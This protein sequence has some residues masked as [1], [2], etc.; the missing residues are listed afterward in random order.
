[1]SIYNFTILQEGGKALED[2]EY[3]VSEAAKILNITRQS[4]YNKVN[5]LKDILQ[6]Y[7]VIKNKTKYLTDKAVEIIRNDLNGDIVKEPFYNI[8]KH[9]FTTFTDLTEQYKSQIKDLQ[10]SVELMKSVYESQIEFIKDDYSKQLEYI[11]KE[12]AKK[13]DQLETKDRLLENM[14]VL[15]RDQK[16]LIDSMKKKPWWQFW[17]RES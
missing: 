4:V 17:K 13:T 3:T 11:K 14:Q 15:L 1:M 5:L 2:K 8:V 6:P 7:I 10:N 16:L 9:D 12:S